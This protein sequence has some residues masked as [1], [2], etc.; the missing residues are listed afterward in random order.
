MEWLNHLDFWLMVATLGAMVYFLVWKDRIQPRIR[1]SAPPPASTEQAD[2]SVPRPRSQVRSSPLRSSRGRW[3]G[4]R[5]LPVRGNEGNE[6][7]TRLRPGNDGV[8]ALESEVTSPLPVTSLPDSLPQDVTVTVAEAAL[9]AV[10]LSS[11]MSP[12]DVAKSLP[13][14]SPKSQTKGYGAYVAKVR[15]VQQ[16]LEA[17]QKAEEQPQVA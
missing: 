14:Y 3:A 8:A 2:S 7:A 5:S 17:A 15:R 13:G 9:I 11:G 1:R 12:S 10:R 16:E 4:S 6:P